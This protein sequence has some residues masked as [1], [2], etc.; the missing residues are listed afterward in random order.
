MKNRLDDSITSLFL[1][2]VLSRG[3]ILI[4]YMVALKGCLF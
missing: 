2:L 4:V 3:E 1:S